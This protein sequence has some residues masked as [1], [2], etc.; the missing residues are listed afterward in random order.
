MFLWRVFL[1]ALKTKIWGLCTIFLARWS[2]VSF[3]PNS[4]DGADSEK[5]RAQLHQQSLLHSAMERLFFFRREDDKAAPSPPSVI[6]PLFCLFKWEFFAGACFKLVF[7]VL[8]FVSP[9]LL[10]ALI[11]FIQDKSKP[12]WIGYTISLSMF[13]VAFLQSL[14]NC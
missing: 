1:R 5:P 11:G 9:P 12:P 2:S 7:D 14:V 4:F 10:N 3:Q 6:W 13:L 8:Q